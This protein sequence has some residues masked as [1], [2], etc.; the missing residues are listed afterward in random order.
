MKSLFL[1]VVFLLLIYIAGGLYL[2]FIQDKK[3][4]QRHYAKVYSPVVAKEIEFVTSD[5]IKLKGAYLE[6][7]K[8]APLVLYFS[9][10]A[11]NAIEFVDKIAPKLK[12]YNF[13][14]FNYPGYAE[15][16]GIPSEKSILKYALEIYDKYKPDIVMGRSLGSAVAGFLASKRDVKGVVLIT[17]FDSIENIAKKRYPFY[18]ISVLLK[19]KFKEYEFISHT[20]APVVVIALKND[21]VIPQESLK[22]LLGHINNLKNIYYIDGVKHGFIYDH[23]QIT[24]I[25]N[26]A[27]GEIIESNSF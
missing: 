27:L 9:G 21:D 19:H 10:N 11:N 2:Y 20:N 1:I 17:P 23:P 15:S 14:A 5:G 25:I 6:N 13:I 7:K 3:V 18:P 22:N 26:K 24:E 4:F 8:D 12:N 16:E